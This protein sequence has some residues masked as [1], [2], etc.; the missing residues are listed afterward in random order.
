L[1]SEGKEKERKGEKKG[2]RKGALNCYIISE[3]E[4]PKREGFRKKRDLSWKRSGQTTSKEKCKR[5]KLEGGNPD[6][7][8]TGKR[9][10]RGREERTRFVSQKKW[11]GEDRSD[12]VDLQMCQKKGKNIGGERRTEKSV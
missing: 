6:N 1:S 4:P 11:W 2:K 3:G 9:A 7:I 8:S 12:S 10:K 5:A